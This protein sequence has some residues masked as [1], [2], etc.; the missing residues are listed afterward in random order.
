MV[1]IAGERAGGALTAAGLLLLAATGCTGGDP[2]GTATTSAPQAAPTTSAGGV[3]PAGT[4]PPTAQATAVDVDCAAVSR[5]RED[6][7][8][9]ISDELDRLGVGRS[10]VR[11]QA[12]SA[13]V[14]TQRGPD[15]Y[16]AVVAATAA[17]TRADAELV[18]GY[19]RRLAAEVG[20][21]DVGS[22]AA[23]E[24]AAAMQRVDS[25]TA[26]AEDPAVLLAQERVQ[27]AIERACR[28]GGTASATPTGTAT[29]GPG[30]SATGT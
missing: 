8:D 16:A 29:G 19:Y 4:D 27:A 25:A 7:D 14:T 18:L 3:A 1:R 11:A 12:V 10:D 15:Y 21:L 5:A 2:G 26:A 20:A 23:A 28:G 24:L 9:A 17:G 6:L 13:L 30:S 22:G